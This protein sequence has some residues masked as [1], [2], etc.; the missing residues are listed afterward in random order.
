MAK[1]RE[2]ECPDC[3]EFEEVATIE[4]CGDIDVTEK[5]GDT[6][7][8][9]PVV[10]KCFKCGAQWTEYMRLVYDGYWDKDKEYN[11]KGEVVIE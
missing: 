2:Y 4:S 7:E 3:G 10:R 9:I 11:A 6:Y 8:F 1:R 5:D